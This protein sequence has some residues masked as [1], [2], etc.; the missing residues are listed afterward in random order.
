[1][2]TRDDFRR[3]IGDS[4]SGYP[5]LGALLQT[6]DPRLLQHIEAMASM[7]ALYSSQLEVAMAEPFAK[8]R[9]ATVLADA[10]MRGLVPQATPARITVTARNG[11]DQSVTLDAGRELRDTSGRSW[12]VE[13]PVT[14]APNASGAFLSAR[15]HERALKSRFSGFTLSATWRR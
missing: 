8:T 15:S 5:T 7:L 10:A 2:L 12:I 1:M 9:D 13:T 6:Q 11:A 4:I 3:A 14:L